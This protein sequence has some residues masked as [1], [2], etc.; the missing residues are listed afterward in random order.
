MQ[1]VVGSHHVAQTRNAGQPEWEL[2]DFLEMMMVIVGEKACSDDD[3]ICLFVWWW[4]ACLHLTQTQARKLRG[5]EKKEN[6]ARVKTILQAT[7]CRIGGS[8]TAEPRVTK[9]C[10]AEK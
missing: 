8:C 10:A 2:I 4:L 3:S 1:C 9:S 7:L 6:P 5:K